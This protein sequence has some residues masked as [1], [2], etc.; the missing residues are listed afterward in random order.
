MN[1]TFI[2]REREVANREREIVEIARSSVE[3]GL[4]GQQFIA[5]YNGLH[6]IEIKT[7]LSDSG[8]NAL[9]NEACADILIEGP[10]LHEIIREDNPALSF[11]PFTHD[12][13]ADISERTKSFSK[14]ALLGTP[15]LFSI[16]KHRLAGTP[17]EVYLF[18]QDN[19]LFSETT[20]GFFKCDISEVPK[21]FKDEFDLVIADP[22]WYPDDYRRWLSVATCVV[23]PGGT[24]IF[25]LFPEGVRETAKGERRAILEL[26]DSLFSSVSIERARVLYETPSFEQVQLIRSGIAPLNWRSA[27]LV[28]GQ[29]RSEKVLIGEGF[30]GQ[31]ESWIERRIGSGRIF[32]NVHKP[33]QHESEWLNTANNGDRFLSSPSRRDGAL[34][35]ANIL[36]SRGHGLVCADPMKFTKLVERIESVSDIGDA[37][38]AI[39]GQSGKLFELVAN[40]LWGRYIIL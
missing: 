26:A 1:E 40:D 36:S 20:E 15:S 29:A 33:S 3:A 18:D 32:V 6:P 4:S 11:W 38:S 21:S 12:T 22:P 10:T 17:S 24:V 23:R 8:A 2:N 39:G 37:S 31:Q 16:A 9:F 19:Y 7:A 30:R 14:I 25:V 13:A 34:P 27:D 5:K 35:K 28:I